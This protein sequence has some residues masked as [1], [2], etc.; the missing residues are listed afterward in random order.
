MAAAAAAA[1]VTRPAHPARAAMP[2]GVALV[3]ARARKIPVPDPPRVVR[4]RTAGT[5]AR[6]LTTRTMQQQVLSQEAEAGEARPARVVLA[7]R[8]ECG[9]RDGNLCGRYRSEVNE[10]LKLSLPD[11]DGEV[12]PVP[13]TGGGHK[14]KS[15]LDFLSNIIKSFNDQ[16]G[17]IE[18]KDADRIRQVIAEELPGKVASDKAY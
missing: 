12:G 2:C 16:F 14:P 15:E 7:A 18:W 13:T 10:T 8:G 17:N 3:V 11:Q 1:L 5:V 6:E 9:L 4:P